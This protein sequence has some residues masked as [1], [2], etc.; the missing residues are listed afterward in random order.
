MAGKVARRAGER[1]ESHKNT[2]V[3]TGGLEL[4]AQNAGQQEQHH[5]APPAPTKPQIKPTITPQAT[6]W[7]NRF[8]GT[9]RIHRLLGGHHRPDEELD[10]QEEG[11]KYREAAHGRVGEKAGDPASHQVNRRTTAIITRPFLMSR[12]L[13]LR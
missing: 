3:P 2:L 10:A 7:K 11:H 9:D 5:H 12:F 6:D 4:I 13:F 8:P 1:G